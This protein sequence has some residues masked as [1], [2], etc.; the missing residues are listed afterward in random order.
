MNCLSQYNVVDVISPSA[1]RASIA[2]NSVAKN[3]RCVLHHLVLL[4]LL[5]SLASC[6]VNI[7]Q[8]TEFVDLNRST[9]VTDED[10]L[11]DVGIVIFDEGLGELSDD[12]INQKLPA[13]RSA[14]S[15]YMPIMLKQTLS[16]ANAWGEILIVND[17][18]FKTDV[19]VTA[20]IVSSNGHTA[21]LHVEVSDATGKVWL[22]KEYIE[23]VGDNVYGQ[24]RLGV[25]DPFQSLYNRISNDMYNYQKLNLSENA[26]THIRALSEIRF[27]SD[28]SSE[29]FGSYFETIE[30]NEYQLV[31]LPSEDDQLLA[32]VRAIRERDRMFQHLLLD[33]YSRFSREIGSTYFDWRRNNYLELLELQRSQTTARNN[34]IKGALWL[35]AAVA[36]SDVDSFLGAATT[37]IAA[38][39]GVNLITD[40][41]AGMEIS[42]AFI[43]E[44]TAS[45]GNDVSTQVVN[46]EE[47]TIVLTGTAEEQYQQ[48]KNYL[49]E[50]YQAYNEDL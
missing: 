34:V 24:D 6:V 35:G 33:R 40:G 23:H 5:F 43:E 44:S 41:L 15:H 11:L 29:V 28:F 20:T 47:E 49:Q 22:N 25:N 4:L 1:I 8:E 42:S 3:I 39:N 46:L 48:W 31:R 13:I 30:E 2:K 16:Y 14:E 10:Q 50:M 32:H 12:E 37:A 36:A 7:P 38:T 17:E 9:I 45:F 19:L 26:N 18:N 27:A 21:H